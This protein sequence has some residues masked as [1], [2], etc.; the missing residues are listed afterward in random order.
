M[1]LS[2]S[3]RVVSVSRSTTFSKEGERERAGAGAESP[4]KMAALRRR[5]RRRVLSRSVVLAV[6]SDGPRTDQSIMSPSLFLRSLSSPFCLHVCIRVYRYTCVR[7]SARE[8]E[9][10]E[11]RE[12]RYRM[13]E[14]EAAA[15]RL[16]VV[17]DRPAVIAPLTDAR[18]FFARRGAP[19]CL[20]FSSSFPRAIALS[21]S[22][23]YA[24]IH[25]R[26][27]I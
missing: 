14:R 18:R 22:Y 17:A 12:S 6:P 10:G 8:T 5:R 4:G 26:S 1:C 3:P 16:L 23:V 24:R 15:A 9:D 20:S 19:V 13:G 11:K 25:A 7:E 2:L 27:R 21:R